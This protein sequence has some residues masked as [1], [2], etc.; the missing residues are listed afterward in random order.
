M[1]TQPFLIA[2]AQGHQSQLR[3]VDFSAADLTTL[4]PAT[5]QYSEYDSSKKDLVNRR[6]PRSGF[7]TV[8]CTG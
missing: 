7:H 8:A 6:T 4:D 5:V 2:L 3:Q 1:D